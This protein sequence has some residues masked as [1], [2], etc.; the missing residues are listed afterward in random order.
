MNKKLI[1][2]KKLTWKTS[3]R[4]NVDNGQERQKR[5][6]RQIYK[7]ENWIFFFKGTLYFFPFNLLSDLAFLIYST[8]F[9]VD[10]FYQSTFFPIRR[11]LHSTLFPADVFY[12]W[13]FCPLKHLLP[14]FLCP[15]RR[16]LPSNVLSFRRFLLFDVFSVDLLSYSTFCLSTFFTVGVFYFNILSVN[17]T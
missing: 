17:R 2:R 16:Y 11:L 8:L 14:T 12:F 3:N 15:F 13:T 9:P 4:K 7:I 5:K 10:V 1:N 6:K